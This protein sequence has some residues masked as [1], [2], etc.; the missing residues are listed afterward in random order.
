MGNRARE[1]NRKDRPAVVVRTPYDNVL[2]NIL[3][4]P[5]VKKKKKRL[6]R[7]FSVRNRTGNRRGIQFISVCDDWPSLTDQTVFRA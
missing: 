1:L 7:T 3:P 5:I 4:S 2:T 6:L